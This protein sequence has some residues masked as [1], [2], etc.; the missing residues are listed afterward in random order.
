[1]NLHEV[2]HDWVPSRIKLATLVFRGVIAQLKGSGWLRGR[3]QYF[4]MQDPV[5]DKINMLLI[6]YGAVG[7]LNFDVIRATTDTFLL[8]DIEGRKYRYNS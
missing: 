3:Y 6:P 2:I 1:M 5:A 7:I 8:L 4:F